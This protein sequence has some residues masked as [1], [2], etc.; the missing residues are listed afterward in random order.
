V[1]AL[2]APL[3]LALG[4]LALAFAILRGGSYPDLTNAY[5]ATRVDSGPFPKSLTSGR[6]ASTLSR[7]PVRIASLTLS[8]D[9]ILSRMTAP[10][11]VRA[12]TH[13]VDD[14]SI[15]TC[16]GFAPGAARV[17]GLEPERIISLE[18]DLVF[19]AHYSLESAVRIL[20]A[21]SIPVVRFREA[22]SFA[23][24]AENVRAVARA[25]GDEAR[26]EAMIAAM[27]GD[28]ARIADKVRGAPRPRVLYYSG[29]GYTAFRNT[30]VGEKIERAGGANATDALGLTG[31]KSAA[32]DV[33]VGLDPDVI[34]VPRWSTD[35]AGPIAEITESPA[36]RESRAVKN[37][38]VYAIAAK[39]LTSESPD[40]VS[41]V[42]LLARLLHPEAFSS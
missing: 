7:P 20:T 29:G 31:M 33:L 35:E 21:A 26:G 17:R 3:L 27:R 41:G 1:K 39:D 2:L 19:V 28:L 10:E 22:N 6:R 34:V 25:T 4:T 13:F 42:E 40:S 12:L 15:S 18:P 16:A 5:G 8:A 9:E 38:H 11:R 32:L 14:P 23:D 37:R 30:I 36:F 24:V